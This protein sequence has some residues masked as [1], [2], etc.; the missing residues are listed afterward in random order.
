MGPNKGQKVRR[1]NVV[2]LCVCISIWVGR[3]EK[4]EIILVDRGM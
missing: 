1:I 3:S 2:M 4:F